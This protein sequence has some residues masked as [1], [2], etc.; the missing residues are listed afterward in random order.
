VAVGVRVGVDVGV[1]LGAAVGVLVGVRVGVVVGVAVGVC[2]GVLVGVG[3]R[4]GVAVGVGVG[5][6]GMG[7]TV[8]VADLVTPL[9]TAEIVTFVLTATGNV[10]T[11]TVPFL[12]PAGRESDGGTVA[13]AL[14]E[15]V[16][17]TVAPAGGAAPLRVTVPVDGVPPM[18]LVGLRTREESEATPTVRTAVFVTPP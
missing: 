13:T 10:V 4:V 14:F 12:E 11:V 16:S 6:G 15:L 3:V 7:R 17:V 18:T 2:V 9:K 1:A 5:V 8:R